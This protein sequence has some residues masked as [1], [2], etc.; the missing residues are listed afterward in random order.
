M[1]KALLNAFQFSKRK[2]CDTNGSGKTQQASGGGIELAQSVNQFKSLQENSSSKLSGTFDIN[3]VLSKV[4]GFP[5]N[6]SCLSAFGDISAP[7]IAELL[8]AA[9]FTKIRAKS[10]VYREGQIAHNITYVLEGSRTAYRYSLDGR[11]LVLDYLGRR[12]FV[13]EVA[14]LLENGEDKATFKTR[15][16]CKIAEITVKDFQRICQ[17][18]PECLV[19]V[20]TQLAQRLNFSDDRIHDLFFSMLPVVSKTH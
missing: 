2:V 10:V 12:D 7:A 14:M 6:I 17:R 11:E 13:G 16:E 20:A 3:A 19:R 1:A 15:E 18:H 8:R 5:I 9:S 4:A